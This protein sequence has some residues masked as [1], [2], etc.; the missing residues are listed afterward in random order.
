MGPGQ[1]VGPGTICPFGNLPA[2]LVNV[3]ATLKPR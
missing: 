3:S 2:D 1:L